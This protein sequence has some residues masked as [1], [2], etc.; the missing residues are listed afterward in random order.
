MCS[1]TLIFT[2][3][4]A[5]MQMMSAYSQ[6]QTIRAQGEATNNYYQYLAKQNKQQALIAERTGKRRS[7]LIQDAGKLE[8][9]KLVLT[10]AEFRA[11]QRAALAASGISVDSVT[12][13]DIQRSTISKQKLDEASLR[14]KTD[15]DS[16]EAITS[17]QNRA[18]ALRSQA[19]GYRVAGANVLAQ[20]KYSSRMTM[21][22][23][24]ANAGVTMFTPAL[25]S[26][27]NYAIPGF[28][29]YGWR[30][31]LGV[32]KGVMQGSYTGKLSRVSILP[33]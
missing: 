9:K 22:G 23:G 10:N 21:L 5:G 28:G 32:R 17:A 2:G 15:I 26:T 16:Y 11:S 7:R 6:A 20:S 12:A 24:I 13:G 18:W 8:G 14:F 3:V 30:T 19:Q 33:S 29:G 25:S 4:S 1:P 27:M 31:P